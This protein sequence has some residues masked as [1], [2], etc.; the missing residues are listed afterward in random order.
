[1]GLRSSFLINEEGVI[2]KVFAKVKTKS[3]ATDVLA[4]R[5]RRREICL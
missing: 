1:M 4:S 5:L 3:H 2:E